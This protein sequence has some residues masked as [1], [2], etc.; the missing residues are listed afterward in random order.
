MAEE[1]SILRDLY[2]SAF[3]DQPTIKLVG[4]SGDISSESLVGAVKVLSPDVMILGVKVVQPATVEK[5]E[6]VRE[7]RPQL[8]SV[9]LF[10]F[11]DP[12]GIKALRRFSGGASAGFA[13]L[14]KHTID[15]V[16]QLTQVVHS[17]AEGRIIVDPT[18]LG[19]LIHTGD[20]RGSL[21]REL[22]PR[23]LEVLSWMA[24]GYRNETIAGV[25]SRDVKTVERHIN[26]I[27]SKLQGDEPSLDPRV[28]ASL[29]FLKATGLLPTEQ[30][31]QE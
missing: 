26:N 18:V 8:A 19:D 2:Q 28:N 15:T 25:L 12:Q 13:Y 23:E 21:L 4:C 30:L 24:K 29:I 17:V 6:L 11:Y 1:Q 10:G 27:Y 3:K 7:A 9:L 5:L 22:S 14:L 16:E 20:M 31:A